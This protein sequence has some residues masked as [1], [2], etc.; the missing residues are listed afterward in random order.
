MVASSSLR[1]GKF[2]KSNLVRL[3]I[4]DAYE[5]ERRQAGDKLRGRQMFSVGQW[6]LGITH[7]FGE[8]FQIDLLEVED[9]NSKGQL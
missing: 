7:F 6:Q 5:L 3:S 4:T 1:C 9:S 2:M 8:L